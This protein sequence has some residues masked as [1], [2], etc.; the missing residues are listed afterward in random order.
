MTVTIKIGDDALDSQLPDESAPTHK[1]IPI[2]LNIRKTADGDILIFDHPEVDIS[3][4]IKRSLIIV[5]PKESITDK[6][7]DVQDRLFRE[8]RRTGLIIQDS[9]QCGSVYGSMEAEYLESEEISVVQALLLTISNFV[10]EENK[11]INIDN[12][13]E[14]EWEEGLLEPDE[15]DSTELGEVPH[16]SQKGSVRPGYIY[17]PYGISSIYR[18]E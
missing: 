16:S 18:Y 7:Y 14:D 17:S 6:V 1:S 10:K 15:E 13:M 11:F 8:L 12:E 5:F 2:Q 4:A 9:V 3:L